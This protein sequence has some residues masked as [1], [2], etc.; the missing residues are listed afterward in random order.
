ME[1]EKNS[2]KHKTDSLD[3]CNIDA[4]IHIFGAAA[5]PALFFGTA[6]TK[7]QSRTNPCSAPDTSVYAAASK[8]AGAPLF[9]PVI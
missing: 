9:V 6:K 4:G 8:L 3:L 7:E 5:K 2:K 1:F